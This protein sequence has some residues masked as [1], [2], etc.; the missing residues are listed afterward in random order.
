MIT[1]EVINAIYKQYS[2]KPK[3][4]DYLDFALLFDK[5][6]IQHDILIDPETEEMTIASIAEDSPFHAI[7]LRN[8]YA[9]IPFE[10]WTAIVMHSSIVFLNV[11]KP[12]TSIHI[13]AQEA[14]F[15]DKLLRH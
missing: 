1:K 14:S 10:E 9:I 2:K 11:K 6:G 7:P 8:I 12:V 3:S 15:W 4:P 5:A 13:K